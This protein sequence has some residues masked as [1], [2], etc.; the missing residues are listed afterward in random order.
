MIAAQEVATDD[1]TSDPKAGVF[2]STNPSFQMRFR[3]KK[4]GLK[5]QAR[6]D[7]YH[8]RVTKTNRHARDIKLA[9]N[10][11]MI[12]VFIRKDIQSFQIKGK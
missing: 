1:R 5:G 11:S 9:C 6:R 3:L 2:I 10:V 8:G 7:R 4:S 12:N